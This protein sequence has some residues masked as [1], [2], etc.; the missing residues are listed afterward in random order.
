MYGSSS[1]SVL[2]RVPR[3]NPSIQTKY[4]HP[5]IHCWIILSILEDNKEMKFKS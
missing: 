1:N 2:C 4:Y 3:L 5:E